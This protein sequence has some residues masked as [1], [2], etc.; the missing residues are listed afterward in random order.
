MNAP[1]E[2]G[3]APLAV[4]AADGCDDRRLLQLMIRWGADLNG[5]HEP[6]QRTPL[7]FA[8]DQGGLAVVRILLEMGADPSLEDRDGLRPDQDARDAD[9][10][11]CLLL[12]LAEQCAGDD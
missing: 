3:R 12:A 4:L 9:I 2:L 6:S 11:E 7:H 8:A 10:Q 1:G 5:R